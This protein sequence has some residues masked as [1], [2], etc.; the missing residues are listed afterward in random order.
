M[1]PPRSLSLWHDTLPTGE[2]ERRRPALTGRVEADVAVVGAGFTGLWT[3]HS[4]ACR[5]PG[6][7]VVVL[8]REFAGFGASGRNGGWLSGL[9]PVEPDAV[10]AASSPAA[11]A[12]WQ[13]AAWDTVDDVLRVAD[14]EGIDARAD[15]GGYL[16]LATSELQARR[17]RAEV[18]AARRRGLGEEDLRW[19]PRGEARARVAA[20]GVFGATFTPHCAAL[21]PA[22]LVRGLADAVERRGVAV[23][24]GTPVTGIAPHRVRTAAGEVRARVVV[25]ALEGYTPAL[26]GHRRTLLPVRS[27]VLATEPLPEGFWAEVGWHGRETLNDARR[28]LVYAQRTR[29]GRIVF[30]GRGAPYRFGSR[31]S[32]GA[33][34]ARGVHDALR[35]SLAELFPALAGVRVTHRWGGVLGVPRDGWPSVGFDPGTGLAHAGGYSG[36]GVALAALAGRTLADLVT[37]RDSEL[38]RLPWV[39]HRSPR[40]EPEPLRWLGVNAGIRLAGLIDDRERR[41]GRPARLLDRAMT[42]LTGH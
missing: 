8:E 3:A 2:L 1:T 38:A 10:A 39:G 6:L 14:A 24:E 25:R 20:D 28:L 31:T 29:D 13:R 33:E 42:A 32:G 35:R 18:A 36:D 23:H 9:L 34:H 12:A 19:L 37:G 22:R 7:R 26:P 15:K 11:A 16:R 17:L 5:D 27:L 30:G 21:D 41:T 4:L 40:F